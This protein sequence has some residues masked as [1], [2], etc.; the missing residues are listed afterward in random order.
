[1]K[2]TKLVGDV[3]VSM[4]MAA[5]LRRGHG[6]LMPFGDRQPYDLVIDDGNGFQRIQ[7][8]TGRI[9]GGAIHFNLSSVVKDSKTKKFYRRGYGDKVDLFGIYCPPINKCYMIPRNVVGDKTTASMRLY[10][11]TPNCLMASDFEIGE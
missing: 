11:P 7:C 6:V 3:S 2:D 5:L 9:Q 8:K 10:T 1:M 4:I